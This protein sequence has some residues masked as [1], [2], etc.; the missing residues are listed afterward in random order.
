MV[1]H[2]AIAGQKSCNSYHLYQMDIS[3]FFS[4]LFS[5]E[6]V[7]DLRKNTEMDPTFDF[8][9][10]PQIFCQFATKK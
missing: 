6:G 7:G 10:F 5:N 2:F 4:N 3:Q 8:L 9:Q 1:I